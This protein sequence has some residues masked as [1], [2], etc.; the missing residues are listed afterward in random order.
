MPP[1][2]APS[3]PPDSALE[4]L[5]PYTLVSR[6]AVGGMAECFLARN[7]G[8]DGRPQLKV[9]KRL[10]PELAADPELA[11]RFRD[12][13]RLQSQLQH[14]AIARVDD[15]G[16][17]EGQSY[18]ALEFIDG[19]DL[20][21]LLAR[22]RARGERL[23]PGLSLNLILRVLDALAYAHR[24]KDA[25]GRELNL[26]H[27][28]I[29]PGNVLV[30]YDGEVKVIDFGLAKSAQSNAHTQP[31]ALLGK[32]LYMSPEM[33]RHQPV[34]KRADLFSTAVLLYELLA[35]EHPLARLSG[36]EILT[37]L[38]QPGFPR[39]EGTVAGLPPGIDAVLQKG[40]ASD[41]NQRF[42]TA[43]ELRG[44][45][46]PLLVAV[47]AGVT[48]EKLGELLRTLF[49]REYANE[50]QL[51]KAARSGGPA[52]RQADSTLR[53]LGQDEVRAALPTAEFPMIGP[54][55]LNREPSTEPFRDALVDPP[56]EPPRARGR[57]QTAGE[58]PAR[59]VLPENGSILPLQVQETMRAQDLPWRVGLQDQA[60]APS[61][62]QE[63]LLQLAQKEQ[64]RR[65]DPT[66]KL[67]TLT[68]FDPEAEAQKPPAP[69]P[70]PLERPRRASTGARRRPSQPAIPI[71]P[72]PPTVPAPRTE[73][74]KTSRSPLWLGLGLGV[75]VLAAVAAAAILLLHQ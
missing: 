62:S 73:P 39:L 17:S 1:P 59:L 67:G 69:A 56:A 75:L 3:P 5:G 44:A 30:G 51:L 40:L 12:E 7:A 57:A 15:V 31:S 64:A 45:L 36:A 35:G 50:R 34:D 53:S 16:E 43:E 71:A 32:L 60:T 19:K 8:P 21:V 47:D 48:L 4:A 22:L 72:P 46:A 38:A 37:R 26:V 13:G 58:V 9:L 65:S 33:V 42:R 61:M 14:A 54:G 25:E 66:V 2:D 23:P 41:P 55:Q 29:S 63:E 74:V 52:P 18:L 10:R 6:L 68:P 70:I 11:A 24:K 27:R 20:G 49:S 28:D